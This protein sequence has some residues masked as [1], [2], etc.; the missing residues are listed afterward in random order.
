MNLKEFFFTCISAWVMSP[1]QSLPG[2]GL[3]DCCMVGK[4]ASTSTYNFIRELV[5]CIPGRDFSHALP[6]QIGNEFAIFRSI[7]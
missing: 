5:K 2:I 7:C 4:L 1:E 3:H 6:S